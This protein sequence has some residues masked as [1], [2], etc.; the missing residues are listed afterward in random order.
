MPVPVIN[1]LHKDLDPTQML[2]P[3]AVKQSVTNAGSIPATTLPVGTI[4]DHGRFSMG[5]P[6]LLPEKVT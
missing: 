2:T 5:Y 3:Q 6:V 4:V 1:R